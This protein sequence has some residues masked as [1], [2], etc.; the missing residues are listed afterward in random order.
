MSFLKTKKSNNDVRQF[1]PVASIRNDEEMAPTGGEDMAVNRLSE[2]QSKQQEPEKEQIKT[3]I[4]PRI[5]PI[6][7]SPPG[8][9]LGYYN[10]IS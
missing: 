7:S 9:W 2:S 1:E 4:K 3:E 6:K 8:S 10:C 5:L